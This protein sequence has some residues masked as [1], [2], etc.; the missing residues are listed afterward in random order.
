MAFMSW[1]LF[2]D[3]YRSSPKCFRLTLVLCR[4]EL[5]SHIFRAE[6]DFF[7]QLIRIII[8]GSI[9][10]F[11]ATCPLISPLWSHLCTPLLRLYCYDQYFL[12]LASFAVVCAFPCADNLLLLSGLILDNVENSFNH[13]DGYTMVS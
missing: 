4:S 12:I 11:I 5:V 1:C 2:V 6:T 3:M 13:Y 9:C 10:C 7:L 8:D